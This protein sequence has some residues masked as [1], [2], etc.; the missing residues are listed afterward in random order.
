MRSST[1]EKDPTV[2][3]ALLVALMA[4]PFTAAIRGVLAAKLWEWFVADTFGVYAISTLQ[5]I[6]LGLLVS[7][8]TY[9][10]VH[11]DDPRPEI[12]QSFEAIIRSL[13]GSVIYFLFGLIV[14]S[15][16]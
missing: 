5:A 13:V 14:V 16:I 7:M 8:A 2:A 12:V 11:D 1:E 4:L 10:H 9:Q 15:L 3:A 6:G